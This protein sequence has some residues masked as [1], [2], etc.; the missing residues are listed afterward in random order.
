M[1]DPVDPT[2]KDSITAS[3]RLNH[4][5]QDNLDK[6]KKLSEQMEKFEEESEER[7]SRQLE[8][9]K[10]KT[11]E[12]KIQIELARRQG[13]AGE[14]LVKK[15][16]KELEK[17]QEIEAGVLELYEKKNELLEESLDLT[18][19]FN[20]EISGMIGIVD[21]LNN[22]GFG[23]MK[24]LIEISGGLM[25]GIH[26]AGKTFSKDLGSRILLSIAEKGQEAFVLFGLQLD[27]VTASLQKA[28]PSGKKYSDILSK[29]TTSNSDA[30]LSFEDVGEAIKSLNEGFTGFSSLGEKQQTDLTKM[31]ATLDKLGVSAQDFAEN[32][33]V[34]N[35]AMGMST[36]E[37]MIFQGELSSVARQTG[38][39]MNQLN[40]D[41]KGASERLS[42]FGKLKGAKI[43]KEME[44]AS[45]ALGIEMNKMLQITEK[46]TTFEGAAEAAGNLNSVLGG[47]VINTIDLMNA[48]LDDP[49]ESFKLIKQSI[50]KTGKSFE[51]MTPAMK[52]VIANAAGMDVSEIARLMSMPMDDAVA[53]MK[54]EADSLEEMQYAAKQATP[55]LQK[56]ET[57]AYKFLGVLEPI[58]TQLGIF[59]DWVAKILAENPKLT[60]SIGY[61]TLGIAALVAGMLGAFK[62]AVMLSGAL[63]AVAAIKATLGTAGIL[64][65]G[66]GAAKD[67][68]GIT[69]WK[70]GISQGGAAAKTAGPAYLSMAVAIVAIGAAVLA[71][72]YG[73]SLF[74]AAFKGMSPEQIYAVSV[75]IVAFTAGMTGMIFALSKVSEAGGKAGV[76]LLP[77]GA[78]I[79]LIGAGI[80]I[81]SYGMAKLVESFV[82]FM[83]EA[84]LEKIASLYL[85]INGLAAAFG[86]LAISMT[87]LMVAVPSVVAFGTAVYF[88]F[89]DAVIEKLKSVAEYMASITASLENMKTEK[90]TALAT[91]A[92][93]AA[94]ITTTS[95]NSDLAKYAAASNQPAAQTQTTQPSEQVIK[96]SINSPIMLNGVKL[97][98][99]VQDE[100]VKREHG[101]QPGMHSNIGIKTSKF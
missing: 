93:M 21:D 66:A 27:E 83:K 36:D 77:L 59:V 57:M 34:A 25:E 73:M 61:I 68:A 17:Q 64:S 5:I 53:G 46:F 37:F 43:F 10:L 99:F 63:Q 67:I 30:Y 51:H 23:K 20:K 19:D 26:E 81:A 62:I 42:Q 84:D 31:A 94:S 16:Q 22:T 33:D 7:R 50:D 58:V 52:K 3:E 28:I 11:E 1:A 85:G 92:T 49:I 38:R 80:G 15:L 69:K 9:E 86:L 95:M 4:Q 72:S 47:N 79:V 76:E 48:S 55:I 89:N 101:Q 97:G 24:K 87:G 41:F 90:L 96:I 45:K 78:A 71:A 100:I 13:T 75:A 91:A 70:E 18:R 35:K 44:V 40:K 2:I 82:L 39:S 98:D 60:A 6:Q 54:A 8:I 56:L 65:G 12:I 29:I 74:V 32:L 14:E 88:S